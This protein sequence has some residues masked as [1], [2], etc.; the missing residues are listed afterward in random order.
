MDNA[1]AADAD[2]AGSG[3]RRIPAVVNVV[4]A[5]GAGPTGRTNA[6][7]AADAV[8]ACGAVLWMSEM[9]ILYICLLGS[10]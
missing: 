7:K 1:G 4:I 8:D 2:G 10:W 9:F 5:E 6:V 3:G